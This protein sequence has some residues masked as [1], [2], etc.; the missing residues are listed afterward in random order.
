MEIQTVSEKSEQ[1]ADP[2][3]GGLM[4]GFLEE[5]ASL[6]YLLNTLIYL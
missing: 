6:S 3:A 1:G 5:V 2:R 4:E